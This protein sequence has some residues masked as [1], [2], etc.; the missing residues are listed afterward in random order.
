MTTD[1][2]NHD[3]AHMFM[4]TGSQI[5]GRP[6]MGSWLT[7]GLG[8]VAENLPGF[9]VLMS[10]GE[11]RSPQPVSARQWSSGFLPS[12]YQGVQLRAKGDPVLYHNR[13]R[14]ESP[15]L[16]DAVVLPQHFRHHGYRAVGGGKIFHTLQ[17]TPG[18]SQNDPAAW[19]AYRGDSPDPISKDWVRAKFESGAELGLIP[20]RPL[21]PVKLF[22]AAPL[23]VP[24]EESGDHLLMD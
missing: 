22:G 19:D 2:I 18:D 14:E 8:S 16:K 11:G 7:R 24:D 13:W 23:G 21:G 12:K 20:G 6:S 4:N 15:V 10:T 5:A 3:P 17:W 1:A 9:V